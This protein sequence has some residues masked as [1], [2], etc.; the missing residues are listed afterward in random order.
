M[1][2]LRQVA[3]ERSINNLAV[4]NGNQ[5]YLLANQEST[6]LHSGDYMPSEGD[7]ANNDFFRILA[8]NAGEISDTAKEAIVEGVNTLKDRYKYIA[9]D[10]DSALVKRATESYI[11]NAG[12]SEVIGQNMGVDDPNTV[13]ISSNQVRSMLSTQGDNK[14]DYLSRVKSYNSLNFSHITWSGLRLLCP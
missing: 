12:Y 4:Y 1:E 10:K 5:K 6:T 14:N 2:I 9:E 13:R 8:K 3:K 7:M 11:A